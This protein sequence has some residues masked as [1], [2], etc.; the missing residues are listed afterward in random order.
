MLSWP[1]SIAVAPRSVAPP[2]PTPSYEY[3]ATLSPALEL[4]TGFPTIDLAGEPKRL[5]SNLING[6]KHLPITLS[7]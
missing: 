3:R 1:R 2:R 6:L 5:R 4:L 7:R